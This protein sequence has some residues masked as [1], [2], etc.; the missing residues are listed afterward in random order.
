MWKANCTATFYCKIQCDSENFHTN[1]HLRKTIYELAFSLHSMS[2]IF[3][4]SNYFSLL[5]NRDT[6]LAAN[7]MSSNYLISRYVYLYIR[8]ISNSRLHSASEDISFKFSL[9]LCCWICRSNCWVIEVWLLTCTCGSWLCSVWVSATAVSSCGVL[10]CR[11]NK[12]I[13]RL[14]RSSWFWTDITQ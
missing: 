9:L 8:K 3:A 14:H 11:G 6:A 5:S 10:V 4:T 7:S 13:L 12:H 2:V 1:R